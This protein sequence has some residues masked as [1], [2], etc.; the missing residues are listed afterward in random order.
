[1]LQT[2]Q[3]YSLVLSQCASDDAGTYNCVATN[4]EGTAESSGCLAVASLHVRCGCFT[5]D[6]EYDDEI[7]ADE[8]SGEIVEI[9]NENVRNYYD[10]GEELNRYVVFLWDIRKGRRRNNFS[11]PFPLYNRSSLFSGSPLSSG[12]S[13]QT[14]KYETH[15]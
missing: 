7:V 14:F 13:W 6:C 11:T 15:Y 3:N 9:K 2:H 5:R 10:I 1:M 4:T 12:K 8:V